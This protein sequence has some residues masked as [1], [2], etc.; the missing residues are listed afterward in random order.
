MRGGCLVTDQN[1]QRM[2]GGCL[3]TDQKRRRMRGG[4]LVTD[5]KRRRMRGGCLVTDQKRRRMLGGIFVTLTE[6]PPGA[7]RMLC[8]GSVRAKKEGGAVRRG[9]SAALLVCRLPH[10]V[11]DT[12]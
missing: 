2:R 3:V 11:S 1:V 12:L 9:G 4:C 7:R 6:A 5:Q 10:K 8:I